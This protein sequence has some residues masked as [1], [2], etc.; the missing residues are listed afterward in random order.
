MVSVPSV[1]PVSGYEKA[2]ILFRFPRAAYPQAWHDERP[3]SKGDLN[4]L[5]D[6]AMA[7]LYFRVGFAEQLAL[8]VVNSLEDKIQ[9]SI[10]APGCRRCC[11]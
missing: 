1:V 7:R 3:S 10:N 11:G 8:E 5:R 4:W 6:V 2:Q 9:I